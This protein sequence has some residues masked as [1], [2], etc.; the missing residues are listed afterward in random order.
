MNNGED[1]TLTILDEYTQFRQAVEAKLGFRIGKMEL[2]D[3]NGNASFKITPIIEVKEIT[4]FVGD[5]P[6]G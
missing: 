1:L 2:V 6:T 3:T 4:V 5:Q